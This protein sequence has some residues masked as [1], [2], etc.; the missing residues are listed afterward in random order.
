MKKIKTSDII[1]VEGKYDKIKLQ[2]LIDATIITTSG[3]GLFNNKQK[4][5]L[6]KKLSEKS[7]IVVLTDSDGAGLVI[8]NKIKSTIGK[9]GEI[10]NI[11]IPEIFGK[12]QRKQK[13]SKEG[14]VG[15]EGIDVNTLR[16]I[17]TKAGLCADSDSVTVKKQ[18]TKSQI[19]AL[20]LSG[21]PD[22]AQKRKKILSD[23][24][25]PTDMSANAFLEAINLLGIE[26]E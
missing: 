14:K 2:S 10:I 16:E 18:Y 12:E 26:I 19:Y 20:G 6:I 7:R 21:K 25:L 15:V 13:A 22:S 8:R 4:Q 24:N 1:V 3:F 9:S 17:F 5:S 11:Y 23:N